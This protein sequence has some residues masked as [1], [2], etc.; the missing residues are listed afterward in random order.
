MYGNK[1]RS[2]SRNNTESTSI[3]LLSC[4]KKRIIA[5]MEAYFRI[6]NNE[7]DQ[8]TTF[9]LLS[10][11]PAFVFRI[12]CSRSPAPPS[13]SLL[14]IYLSIIWNFLFFLSFKVRAYSTIRNVCKDNFIKATI[15]SLASSCARVSFSS[16]RK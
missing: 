2:S 1:K 16:F 7:D 14:F 6:I 15:S 13:L 12:S 3:V 11:L 9:L 4:G 10:F 8:V 5:V